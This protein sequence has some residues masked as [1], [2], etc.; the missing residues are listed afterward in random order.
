MALGNVDGAKIVP[1]VGCIS[2]VL[3]LG[4]YNGW[5]SLH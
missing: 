3:E 5:I 4:A 2:R 1:D